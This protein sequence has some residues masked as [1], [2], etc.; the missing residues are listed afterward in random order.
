MYMQLLRRVVFVA[1]CFLRLVTLAFSIFFSSS[2]FCQ[3]VTELRKNY[4]SALNAFGNTMV[5]GYSC[6]TFTTKLTVVNFPSADWLSYLRTQLKAFFF[7]YN[8]FRLKQTLKPSQLKENL[9]D[10]PQIWAVARLTYKKQNPI[11]KMFFNFL[12][13]RNMAKHR[14][15]FSAFGRCFGAETEET[16]KLAFSKN[17]TRNI[18]Y[19]RGIPE[20]ILI[21][22]SSLKI[23]SVAVLFFFH[24]V[25]CAGENQDME[26]NKS[27]R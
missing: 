12:L 4:L 3:R 27:E 6:V 2:S 5:F 8:F 13:Q 19:T 21:H 9:S 16:H 11:A 17:R 22:N 14:Q 25:R 10:Y 18:A 23:L 7:E 26:T 15:F 1:V 24:I 20:G